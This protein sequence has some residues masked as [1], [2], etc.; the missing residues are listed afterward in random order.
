[1]GAVRVP[2]TRTPLVGRKSELSMLGKCLDAALDG[3][4]RLVLCRGEPGIGKTRLVDELSACARSRGAVVASGVGFESAGAP[5]FWPWRQVVRS[6][7]TRVDLAGIAAEHGV[8]ADLSRLAREVFAADPDC[9]AGDEPRDGVGVSTEDRFRLFDAMRTLLRQAAVRC[10]LL[11]A[12]DDAHWAD[13][14]SL[15]LLQHLV[16]T[17]SDERLLIV[18]SYRDTEPLPGLSVLELVREPATRTLDVRGLPASSVADQLAAVVG[19]T[20]ADEEAARVHALTGGNP[21]FVG[22]IGRTLAE[23][24][25]GG[26]PPRI[27]ADV[28][29]AIGARLNRLSPDCVQLLR[30]ASIIGHGFTV[31]VLAAMV[32]A[33]VLACLDRLDQAVVAGLIQPATLPGEHRFGHALIRDAIESAL[34]T[35]ERVRL[36]RRAAES[37]ELC[38]AGRLE[39]HLSDLARHWTVAAVDGH[40]ATAAAWAERAGHEAIRRLA[41][42]DGARLFQLALEVGAGEQDEL[43][44]CRLHLAVGAARHLSGDVDGRLDACLRAAELARR[45][46]RA[47]LL[48]QAA[49]QLDCV[50]FDHPGPG[51]HPSD[52]TALRLCVDALAALSPEPT[53]LRARTS[54]R[55]AELCSYL[56]DPGAAGALSDA[57]MDLAE[58]CGDSDAM[59]AAVRARQFVCSGPDG[60]EERALLSKR[61]LQLGRESGN[62][63]AQTWA[64]LWAVDVAL[65]RGDLAEAARE[66]DALPWLVDQVRG[67]I[68][69]WQLLVA[70]ATLAQAHARFDDALRFADQAFGALA[71]TGSP[72][73]FVPRSAL[74]GA[75]GHHIGLGDESGALAANGL[76]DATVDAVEIPIDGV[77]PALASAWQLAEAGRLAQA[78]AIYR[79]LGPVAGWRPHP[80]A[81]L[82]S[83]ALGIAA[84]A[85]LDQPADV[86]A[87]RKR[88]NRYRGHHLASG[89]API[90]YLG[91]V[92]LWLG[93]AAAYLGLAEDAVADLDDAVRI[94]ARNGAAGFHAEA[95][96]ELAAALARRDGPGDRGRAR[97]LGGEAARRAADLGMGPYAA[98]AGRLMEQLDDSAGPLTPREREVAEL[99]TL[100]LTNREIAARLYLSERTAQNH[101]Q[102]ILTKLD[103]PNRSQIAVW[104]TRR[105]GVDFPRD[106]TKS[107]EQSKRPGGALRA[108]RP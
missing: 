85:A 34:S 81:E 62:A 70:R 22:E 15:L 27:T 13:P 97:A 37:V 6:L 12:I 61:M 56:D 54:A 32:D 105:K 46:N 38:Y 55:L 5:P 80:H 79:S 102:H 43:E 60:L 2:L 82:F 101:V 11:I 1:M 104:L 89:A 103:L 58:R 92:E 48:A 95:Q 57:A 47:D 18:A 66:V 29:D 44:R 25:V 49:L 23:R 40:R 19:P 33:P 17:L 26:S 51:G 14:S 10:P 50:G 59:V 71:W 83:Y 45:N 7:S 78:A 67:P 108:P 64:H 24:A 68:A 99:V 41:F 107:A 8:T 91:P 42:E 96:Y 76:A 28:R 88:L 77:I 30:A 20:L 106:L 86:A 9:R 35:A 87:Q 93:I 73:A 4:P 72:A 94:C 52:A 69:R 53:A 63:D 84:A 39:R 36:H 98:K 3:Q 16:R 100:G 65:A 74:L 75:V 31:D 21:F 90:L